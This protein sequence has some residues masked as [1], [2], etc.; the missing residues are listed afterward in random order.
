VD[1]VDG[2][3]ICL[4]ADDGPY[5]SPNAGDNFWSTVFEVPV[6]VKYPGEP[7]AYQ[8]TAIRNDFAKLE[9]AINR[10]DYNA[11]AELMDIPSF[12]NYLIVQELVYNVEI[13]APRSVFIHKD[14]GGKYVMGPV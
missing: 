6:C 5:Y 10:Y 9:E 13:D 1:N 14:A 12:I 8:L 2:L 11:V 7:T 4:D 3:L